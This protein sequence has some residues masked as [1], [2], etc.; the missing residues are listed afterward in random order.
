MKKVIIDPGFW[1]LF[2]EAQINI[3]TI[4]GFDNHDT[5]E[6]HQQRADLLAQAVK[7]SAKF[8]SLIHICRHSTGGT[9]R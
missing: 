2:P 8:L 3:M 4:K 7:E 6:T 5:P 1:E 9:S